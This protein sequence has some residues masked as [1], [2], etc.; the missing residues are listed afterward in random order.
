MGEGI[1]GI[2]YKYIYFYFKIAIIIVHII[3]I[4]SLALKQFL[5]KM[6]KTVFLYFCNQENI[7]EKTTRFYVFERSF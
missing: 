4:I 3:Y 2:E 1:L 5:T 6:L 7:N